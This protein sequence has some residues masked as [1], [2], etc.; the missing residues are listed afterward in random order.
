VQLKKA[1]EAD[2]AFRAE[3]EKLVGEI[4]EKGGDRINQIANVTGNR[5]ITTQITG[6][7]NVVR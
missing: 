2:P 4:Q 7:G 1:L 5:N 6:S 3:L